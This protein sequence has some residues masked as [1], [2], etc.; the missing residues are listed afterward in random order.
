MRRLQPGEQ[1]ANATWQRRVEAGF[2]P[3][4]GL[5]PPRLGRMDC[6]VCGEEQLAKHFRRKGIAVDG[7]CKKC[8]R[9]LPMVREA[10]ERHCAFCRPEAHVATCRCGCGERP[11]F[12]IGARLYCRT[13]Y[14]LLK[15]ASAA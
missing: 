9:R 8:Y 3:R 10:N 14:L 7:R 11:V 4:C 1:Y 5:R 2:C 12:M 6:E 13:T 15:G